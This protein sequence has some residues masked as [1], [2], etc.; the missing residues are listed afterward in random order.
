MRS[1]NFNF[2]VSKYEPVLRFP[3]FLLLFEFVEFFYQF[4][5]DTITHTP[6]VKVDAAINFCA[7]F[8]GSFVKLN[9]RLA[10][11][12]NWYALKVIKSGIKCD[13]RTFRIF[14]ILKGNLVL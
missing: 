3:F 13:Y 11:Y 2:I 5:H 14:L 7:I 6:F 1:S 10:I 4:T 8:N 12:N 9:M